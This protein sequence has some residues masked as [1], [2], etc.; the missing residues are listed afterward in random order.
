MSLYSS[1]VTSVWTDN[2]RIVEKLPVKSSAV[3]LEAAFAESILCSSETNSDGIDEKTSLDKYVNV[4]V[5]YIKCTKNTLSLV[6]QKIH[7]RKEILN[8]NCIM[9][10]QA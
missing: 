9:P 10:R 7:C 5:Y 8:T 3:G 1:L 4:F 6:E 2:S